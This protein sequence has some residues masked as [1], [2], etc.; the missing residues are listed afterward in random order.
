M[1]AIEEV[2]EVFDLFVTDTDLTDTKLPSDYPDGT[3]I[4]NWTP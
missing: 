3:K 1:V 4:N 2:K